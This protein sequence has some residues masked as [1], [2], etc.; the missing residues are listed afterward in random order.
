MV[1]VSLRYRQRD[2]AAGGQSVSIQLPYC[3]MIEGLLK[4][5]AAKVVD[6]ADLTLPSA[7]DIG[8]RFAMEP[9]SV[10]HNGRM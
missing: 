2:V 8:L 5:E 7:N 6:F 1:R 9:K 4:P 10:M 3:D